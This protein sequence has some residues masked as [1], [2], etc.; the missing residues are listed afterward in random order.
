[1]ELPI[2]VVPKT[3][4]P[5]F[6]WR[7]LVNTP[8]GHQVISHEGSLPPT[9]ETAVVRMIGICKQLVM[10]N[11]ALHGQVDALQRQIEGEA[12]LSAP[13]VSSSKGTKGKGS[14]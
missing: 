1:M 9:V 7:Q 10:D 3:N 6:R 5:R 14:K 8:V 13:E 4:P 11:A 2:E 12:D